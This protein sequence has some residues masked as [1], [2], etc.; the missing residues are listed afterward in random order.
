MYSMRSP[1]TRRPPS[2]FWLS[3]G[4]SFAKR[5]EVRDLADVLLLLLA[6]GFGTRKPFDAARPP[7]RMVSNVFM[8]SAAPETP[9]AGGRSTI[10]G[11][12][13]GSAF[14]AKANEMTPD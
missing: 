14:E 2:D 3:G 7:E 10:W 11:R 8:E 1:H 13:W 5:V 4:F 6:Q 12:G 9:Y